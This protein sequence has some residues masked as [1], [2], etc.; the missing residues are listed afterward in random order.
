[1]DGPVF[2]ATFSS[3][4]ASTAGQ[5]D[6]FQISAPANSRVEICE[7]EVAQLSTAPG[8]LGLQL[9]R[10]ST[11]SGSGGTSPVPSRAAAWGAT[12]GSSVMAN[13]TTVASSAGTEILHSSALTPAQPIYNSRA[14]DGADSRRS[15]SEKFYLE[16]SQRCVLRTSVPSTAVTLSGTLKFR[17]IGLQ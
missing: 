17:E 8:F 14:W 13:N 12:A 1:M 11:T 5:S 15:Q 2:T 10:G 6:L 16:A 4:A 9:I 3:V 7:F